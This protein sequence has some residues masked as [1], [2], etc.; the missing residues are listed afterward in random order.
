[1]PVSGECGG[2]GEGRAGRGACC[3]RRARGG[4]GEPRAAAGGALRRELR[5]A[6]GP[7][8]LTQANPFGFVSRA[9]SSGAP[10]VH[11]VSPSG[12]PPVTMALGGVSHPPET[13]GPLRRAR[14]PGGHHIHQTNL[15]FRKSLPTVPTRAS[16]L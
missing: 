10:Q 13:Q 5:A 4:A 6:A 8:C 14:A 3:P 15:R 7:L 2:G 9:L 16:L 12:G 1:M 11:W